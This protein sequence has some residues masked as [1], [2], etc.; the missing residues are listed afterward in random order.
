[1]ETCE[2]QETSGRERNAGGP[3]RFGEIVRVLL[4]LK[5]TG[6][7]LG[8]QKKSEEAWEDRE[9]PEELDRHREV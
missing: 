4:R 7:G 1:M 9:Y 8:G 6:G 2:G 3:R 5:E